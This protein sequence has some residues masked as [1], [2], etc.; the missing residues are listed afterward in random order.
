MKTP[1]RKVGRRSLLGA[2]LGG[3]IV[4]A[5]GAIVTASPAV[6]QATHVVGAPS[7]KQ[8]KR[9][10]NG[11]RTAQSSDTNEGVWARPVP[12][13]AASVS[14]RAGDPEAILIY[15][16]RRFNYE[17]RPLGKGDVV[18]FRPLSEIAAGVSTNLAS[19][20]A[21]QILPGSFPFGSRGYLFGS[22]L[23]TIR[24]LL[25][26]CAG[27]VAWGGDSDNPDESLFELV[28]GPR[29]K[30]LAALATRIRQWNDESGKGAGTV[31]VGA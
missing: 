10:N 24:S 5:G 31:I 19:G 22:E 6:A 28:K 21:I 18:G 23:R 17:V 9:S 3:A 12:G 11:W 16:A 8:P 2:V 30:D 27:V 26:E 1:S 7:G 14:V 4:V 13:S 29:D 25:A 20:T 15:V